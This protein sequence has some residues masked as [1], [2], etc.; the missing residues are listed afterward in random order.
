MDGYLQVPLKKLLEIS[1]EDRVK[2]ILSSFS[3]PQNKDVTGYLKRSAIEL[4]KHDVSRTHL[5]YTD[6]KGESV[7]VGY[8]T[9]TLKS[10]CVHHKCISAGMRKRL[11]RF[12]AS[13]P[14]RKSHVIPCPLIAQLSKNFTNGYNALIS[15]DELLHM[16]LVDVKRTQ[17]IIG[18]KFVYVECEDK[19]RLV[20]FYK[21]N[22][23]VVFGQRPLDHDEIEDIQGQ[24]Y[25]QLLKYN[26]VPL[27]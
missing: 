15:G 23:F 9:L 2:S 8:Y 4:E 6:F 22:G 18:G 1:G 19:D 14:D 7:L 16:A 27:K 20:D 3:C 5:V 17:E 11:N 24:Y 26:N 12:G 13:D 25:L 10:L 21:A